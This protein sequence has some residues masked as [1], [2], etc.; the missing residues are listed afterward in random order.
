MGSIN[1][2]MMFLGISGSL[3]K[4]SRNTGLLR[5]C[6]QNLPNG[7]TMEIADLSA[8]PFYNEDITERPAVVEIIFKQ[9]ARAHALVFA[10]TEYNYSI[11]PALKNIIDW[12][13]KYPDNSLLKGKSAA[14]LGAGGR[15]GSAR[16][17]YHLRQ[18]CQYVNVYP[19]YQP[20][21]FCSAYSNAFDQAGNLIDEETKKLVATLMLKLQE[22][23]SKAQAVK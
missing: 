3:R 6:T 17:Q 12:A 20:E 10:A 21:I 11:A 7:V 23:V 22:D 8:V 18:V 14:M 19:L 5:A 1:Q 2:P 13:S 4:N 9:L 15:L 16:S